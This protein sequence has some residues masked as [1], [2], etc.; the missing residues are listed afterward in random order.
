MP[1]IAEPSYTLGGVYTPTIPR[2]RFQWIKDPTDPLVLALAYVSL[3]VILLIAVKTIPFSSSTLNIMSK[4]VGSTYSIGGLL[5][6]GYISFHG[7]KKIR[8]RNIAYYSRIGSMQND[9]VEKSR[10]CVIETLNLNVETLPEYVVGSK[11]T[12]PVMKTSLGEEETFRIFIHDNHAGCC[13]ITL[14]NETIL[15]G[16]GTR[17][18]GWFAFDETWRL[19][20]LHSLDKGLLP[21][22]CQ[23]IVHFFNN[24][25]LKGHPNDVTKFPL[26]RHS[27]DE[28]KTTPKPTEALLALKRLIGGEIEGYTPL[29][30]TSKPFQW[31]W[32]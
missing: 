21:N 7:P 6:S 15:P 14:R 32:Q 23:T 17:I 27:Y 25:Q 2:N 11:P 12:T 22:P 3:G 13:I 16:N 5:L 19:R 24:L 8:E 10:A 26:T 1:A 20:A 4:T 9:Q 29:N 31:Q 30:P 28:E 18:K